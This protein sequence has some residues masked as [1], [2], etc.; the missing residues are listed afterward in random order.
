MGVISG[1]ITMIVIL[2]I[3][4]LSPIGFSA[5]LRYDYLNHLLR[6]VLI[7]D[8]ILFGNVLFMAK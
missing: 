4:V 6:Y 3:L 1:I 8:G 7:S 5:I 2:M